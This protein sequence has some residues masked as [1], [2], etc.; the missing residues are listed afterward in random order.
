M[1]DDVASLDEVNSSC[2]I[3]YSKTL[4]DITQASFPQYQTKSYLKLQTMILVTHRCARIARCCSRTIS[5]QPKVEQC[6]INMRGQAGIVYVIDGIR[7]AATG[8]SRL[9][10]NE[11]E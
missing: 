4:G 9:N 11:I 3:W 5:G 8:F 1:K 7:R 2:R 10:P 6:N